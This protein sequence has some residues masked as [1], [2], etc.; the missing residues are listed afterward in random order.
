MEYVY[1]SG[2]MCVC[3]SHKLESTIASPNDVINNK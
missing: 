1:R 3:N 2:Y